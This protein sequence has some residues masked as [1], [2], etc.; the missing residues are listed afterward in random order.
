MLDLDGLRV[1]G[2]SLGGF[3]SCVDLPDLKLCVDVGRLLDRTVSRSFVL[4]THGHADHIGALAQH[5]AQRGLRRLD[6]ATYVVPPGLAGDL[7]E[8]LGVWRRMDR[9]A[10]RATIRTLEPGDELE[11][12]RD[13]VARPFRTDH[14]VPSQGYLLERRGRRLRPEFTGRP[15]ADLA[16]LRGEGADIEEEVREPLIAITG[17]TRISGVL[18]HDDVLRCPRLVMEATFL[19]DRIDA[20]GAAE[21]GH[22]H[23]DDVAEHAHRFTCE[24]LVL[25]HVSPRHTTEEAEWLV[26][27]RLPED[28]A[29]RT[30]VF[31]NDV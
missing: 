19:D 21:R 24:H 13:L 18:E 31:P 11:V 7:E 10:L 27:N 28:L 3:A 6:P 12:R 30:R 17:D 9:G 15:G 22:I 8:L 26:R 20:A 23:L 4:V 25:N 2:V 5:V 16:R 1:S 29:A 14:R